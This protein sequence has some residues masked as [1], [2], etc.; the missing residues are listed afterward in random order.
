MADL[1]FNFKSA[2]INTAERMAEKDWYLFR[3]V[4]F[5]ASHDSQHFFCQKR[6]VS[7]FF[8]HLSPVS[9]RKIVSL[10]IY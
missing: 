7:H 3:P 4:P 10:H 8:S 6:A 2:N 5:C 1:K 9:D